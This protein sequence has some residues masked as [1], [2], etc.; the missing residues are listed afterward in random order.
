MYKKITSNYD[1]L[2]NIGYISKEQENNYIHNKYQIQ[3]PT[4]SDILTYYKKK[5]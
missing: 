2:Y 3:I 1:Y 5:T 4:I